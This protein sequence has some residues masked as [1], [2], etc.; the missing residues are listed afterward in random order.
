M[1]VDEGESNRSTSSNTG[2]YGGDEWRLEDF[3]FISYYCLFSEI[4]DW[5]TPTTVRRF[6]GS[7]RRNGKEQE[8]IVTHDASDKLSPSAE[9]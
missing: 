4:T 8:S 1:T 9:N 7:D 3:I 5:C 2:R 6:K